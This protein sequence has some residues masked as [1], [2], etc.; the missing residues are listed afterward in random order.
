M[1]RYLNNWSYYDVVAFLQQHFFE[2]QMA[3]RTGHRFFRGN[4]DNKVKLVE[5]QFHA[6]K[7]ISAKT[8]QHDIIPKT[9]IPES[10][11]RKW[12]EAGNKKLRKKIRYTGAEEINP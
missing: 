11:W 6:N 4:V 7:A 3:V 5:V 10:Y 1:P 12:A 8:L 2:E 9:G